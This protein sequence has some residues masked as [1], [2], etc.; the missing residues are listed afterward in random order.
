MLRNASVF[1]VCLAGFVSLV[2]AQEP[3]ST[4][5]AKNAPSKPAAPNP[6]EQIQDTA[7]LPRVLLIGDSISMGYTIP[8]R[9][10][11]AGVANVHR[12]ATNCG[13]TSNGVKNIDAWLGNG[14][15][16]VIHF[17]W[18]LHD[19]KYMNPMGT[20]VDVK[21]GKQQIPPADYET[22][23]RQ[24]V[25]RLKQTGAKL[26][27]RNTTPVPV[28]AKGR[29]PDD[30]EKYNAVAAK[31]MQEEKIPTH[32]LYTFAKERAE[33]IQKPKDVHYT[34]AGSKV[35]ADDVVRVIKEQLGK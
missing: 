7:G 34:D 19:L 23:L 5:P 18:G 31:I 22:N 35:L 32:D 2:M 13:P 26:V 1:V 15:W 11:L 20:I 28:G 21:D 4:A 17:N 25:K 8:V 12:P 10:G 14:K 6:L 30:V 3:K 24:L 16:D 33:K 29:I 27:W 9:Q